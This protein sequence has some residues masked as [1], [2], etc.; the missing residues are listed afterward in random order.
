M[1]HDS[2]HGNYLSVIPE[3]PTVRAHIKLLHWDMQPFRNL[4]CSARVLVGHAKQVAWA[5][6]QKA[7]HIVCS[8]PYN[9]LTLESPGLQHVILVTTL[10]QE[11]TYSAASM[12]N[13][14]DAW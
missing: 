11:K 2:T 7:K 6:E 3:Q 1:G 12:F 9:I 8:S 14:C 10:A 4:S 13:K 5:S